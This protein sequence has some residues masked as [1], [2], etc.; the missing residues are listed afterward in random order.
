MFLALLLSASL[1]YAGGPVPNAPIYIRI[2]NGWKGLYP[3]E[4][5]YAEYSFKGAEIKL[6]DPYHVLLKPSLGMMVTFADKKQFASGN[7][8]LND[9]LQWELAYWSKHAA[10]VEPAP[11]DDLGGMRSDLKVTELRLYNN[12]GGRI[13][14][15]LIALATPQ[16]VLVLAISSPGDSSLDPLVKEIVASVK[17]VHRRLDPDEV[18]RLSLE[19]RAKQ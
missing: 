6:Q 15:Y 4:D 18:K 14:V 19:E 7:D 11:R 3:L 17:L 1:S 2:D 13:S 8:L 9:H 16:G 12:Q 5:D 10:R